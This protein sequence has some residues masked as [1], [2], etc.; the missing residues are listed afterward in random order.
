[1]QFQETI[2]RAR[3]RKRYKRFF[4]DVEL[5][6]E[7]LTAHVP[8]TGS[9]KTCLFE[10]SDCVLTESN[11][12]NRKLKATLQ[13]V[14]TP[15]GWA[16]VNTAIANDLVYEAWQEGLIEDWRPMKAAQREYKLSAQT[17]LDLVLAP[18][19]PD[20]AQG[21]SL[22]YIEVK[23]VTLME[24][25]IARFPDAVT[26]RGQKHLRELTELVQQGHPA[27]MIFVVQREGAK[28]FRPAEDI[29]PTYARLLGECAQA[30]VIIRAFACGIQPEAGIQLS[31]Q[32]PVDL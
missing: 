30:G 10:N 11:N 28:S 3:F 12:P 2:L 20:L 1:M 19:E 29:D 31:H 26:E 4:A 8:N 15:E 23:N 32:L 14:R 9:L 16:G 25:T 24:G 5:A 17:R 27:E 18:T 21:K 7:T 22:R 6:G 13:F